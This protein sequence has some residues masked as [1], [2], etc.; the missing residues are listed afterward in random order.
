MSE[1]NTP[2]VENVLTGNITGDVTQAADL[3][4]ED[5]EKRAP[6]DTVRNVISGNVSGTVIQARDIR[7]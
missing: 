7:R 6:G 2:D 1:P 3:G 5:A 4:G